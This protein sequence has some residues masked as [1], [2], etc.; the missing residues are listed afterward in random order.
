LPYLE[1]N[2]LVAKLKNKTKNTKKKNN[3]RKMEKG[4]V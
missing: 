2:E 4:E 1:V 3:K